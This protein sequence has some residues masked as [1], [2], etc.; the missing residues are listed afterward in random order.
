MFKRAETDKIERAR[1]LRR[2]MTLPEKRLWWKLREFNA[3]G[4]HFRRQSPFGIYTL[5][6]VEHDARLV[7]ELD[8]EQHGRQA[9]RARD[10]V[11]DRHLA[12]QGYLT[13]RFWNEDVKENIDGVVDAILREVSK[14]K[15]RPPPAQNR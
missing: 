7:V 15:D 4:Y 1:N 10:A 11:R 6:F 14:R 3:R 5:D 9:N 2:E 13:L 12:S 8:G